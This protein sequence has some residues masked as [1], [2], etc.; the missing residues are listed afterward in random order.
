M[1]WAED[2]RGS[3]RTEDW[4]TQRL[5]EWGSESETRIE[6]EKATEP[7]E[8]WADHWENEEECHAHEQWH[9]GRIASEWWGHER[10]RGQRNTREHALW[11]KKG[12]HYKDMIRVFL[13]W[14][15]LVSAWMADFCVHYHG[16]TCTCFIQ[17]IVAVNETCSQASIQKKPCGHPPFSYLHPF[18]SLFSQDLSIL[19]NCIPFWSQRGHTRR[20]LLLSTIH[21]VSFI[22]KVLSV[23]R[24]NG[25]ESLISIVFPNHMLY[26]PALHVHIK[27]QKQ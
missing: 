11:R 17:L 27:C 10:K 14:I 25:D 26:A 18:W 24:T 22:T 20:R 4:E 12:L 7:Q 5:W 3:D 2:S 13:S 16:E 6:Q 23:L 8:D 19:L 1:I 9:G 15:P 21:R